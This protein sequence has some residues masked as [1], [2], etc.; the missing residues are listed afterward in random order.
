[1][2]RLRWFFAR[3]AGLVWRNAR[4]RDLDAELRFHLDEDADQ[5]VADGLSAPEARRRARRSVGNLALTREDAREAWVWLP[6]EHLVRDCRYAVRVLRTAAG[7]HG[8]RRAVAGTGHRRQHGRV[9]PGQG[10]SL[11][12]TTGRSAGRNRASG[13]RTRTEFHVFRVRNVRADDPNA[14][15]RSGVQHIGVHGRRAQRAPFYRGTS[16]TIRPFAMSV[17]T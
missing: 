10:D 9:Q 5:R 16:F 8:D 1:M 14:R 2:R 4:E 12:H 7:S 13:W 11:G 6:L 15:G 17:S 3:F